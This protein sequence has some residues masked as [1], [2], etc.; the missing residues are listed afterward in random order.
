VC[1][2]ILPIVEIPIIAVGRRALSRA[3]TDTAVQLTREK[4]S[5]SA[6]LVC[7][8]DCHEF[9]WEPCY[10]P[11]NVGKTRG[12]AVRGRGTFC[13]W[14]CAKAYASS[15]PAIA[16]CKMG[17][18]LEANRS[19]RRFLGTQRGVEDVMY[20]KALPAREKLRMFG[21]TMTIDEYR[22]GSPRFD[23]RLIG[24]DGALLQELLRA[25]PRLRDDLVPR[26]FIDDAIVTALRCS[27]MPGSD[28]LHPQSNGDSVS[29]A[30]SNA[31][32]SRSAAG[33]RCRARNICTDA[34]IKA[35]LAKGAEKMDAP[36]PGTLMSTMGLTLT[37]TARTS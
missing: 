17:I 30:I 29:E 10:L 8:H 12:C 4:R 27:V 22:L 25:P 9:S 11:T 37:T 26:A 13:S 24:E 33:N 18:S 28:K 36:Q 2:S 19:R 14:S 6:S 32:H 23:G 7:W 15:N 34:S 35:R 5:V 21:G 16:S 31:I 3:D 20:I 1:A